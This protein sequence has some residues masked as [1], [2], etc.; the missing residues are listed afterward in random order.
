[1]GVNSRLASRR[2]GG[3]IH[4]NCIHSRVISS[5][6]RFDI[7]N[8]VVS[9]CPLARTS[10]I[11]VRLF[12]ARISSVQAF[13]L[14]S[15]ESGRG[16]GRVSVKPTAR[17]PL[18]SRRFRALVRGLRGNLKSDLGGL[19]SSGTG[20]RLTRG[21]NCRLRRLQVKGGPRR[22]FGCLS[23]T[24]RR[25]DDLMSCLPTGNLVFVSRVDHIRRVG[26]SLSGRR[27]R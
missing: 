8:K 21:I 13:S 19:G 9:V 18:S 1:M 27:T 5:P 14:R 15:R 3:F 10:P 23:F 24:F 11:E 2:L 25:K 26:S 6:K 7:E 12:S 20:A 4:V 17:V 22:L 16:L